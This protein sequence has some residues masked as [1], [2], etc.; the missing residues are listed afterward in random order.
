MATDPKTIPLEQLFPD[1]TPQRQRRT[2]QPRGPASVPGITK[3]VFRDAFELASAGLVLAGAE[4][5]ALTKEEIDRMADAWYRLAK[6]YPAFGKQV[7]QGNKMTVWGNLFIVNAIV[8]GK[9]IDMAMTWWNDRPKKPPQPRPVAR[10][11]V[12]P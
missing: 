1:G 8:L 10:P 3:E 11:Q 5:Y 12:I 6:E 2:R 9:R 4:S 7:A